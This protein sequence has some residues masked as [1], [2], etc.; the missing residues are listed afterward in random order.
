[1]DREEIVLQETCFINSEYEL[2]KQCCQYNSQ[3]RLKLSEVNKRL[4]ELLDQTGVSCI[5]FH[6][7]FLLRVKSSALVR[8]CY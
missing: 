6:Y 2:M 1:M 8:G 7:A 3:R 5:R 4:D